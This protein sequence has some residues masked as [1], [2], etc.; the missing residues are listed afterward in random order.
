MQ[1]IASLTPSDRAQ[2]FEDTA[3]ELGTI[4]EP[5]LIEKDFWVCWVLDQLFRADSP[6]PTMI[7]KG[8][9]SLSKGYGA[10]ERFSEDVD[11][12]LDR[13]DLGFS[14]KRD[15]M[16]AE[17]RKQ[18]QTLVSELTKATASQIQGSLRDLLMEDFSE[19]LANQSDSWTIESDPADEDRQT[20]LFRY[21][22]TRITPQ[23]RD[24]NPPSI[25][26]EFGARS[27]HSPAEMKEISPYARDAFPSAFPEAL[28]VVRVLALERTFWEK[29]TILHA[30]SYGGV[31]KIKLRDSRHCYD[32]YQLSEGAFR[33]RALG[34]PDLLE[35]VVAHKMQFYYSKW[36]RYDLAEPGT[37]RLIPEDEALAALR[38]DYTRMKPMFFGE[39]HDFRTIMEALKDMEAEINSWR[40]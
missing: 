34:R 35:A 22:A 12:A 3:S 19:G 1:T 32:L 2:L 17:T 10:I 39:P 25:K 37:F 8:G 40:P 9:T 4:Q 18:A 6:Y 31:E 38:T 21:P 13:H 33:E 16:N 11:L 14:G 7:F 20:L 28:C 26:L 36:A 29:A 27:D 15:P 5:G 24:Y 30:K 23:P